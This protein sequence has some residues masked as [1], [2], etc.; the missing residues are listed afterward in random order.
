MNLQPVFAIVDEAQFSE[1]IHE[2]T[3]PGTGC[4]YHI[5]KSLLADLGNYR[6]GHAFLAEMSQQEQNP[7]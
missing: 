7:R 1:P 6:F 2:K 3:D 4:A 5:G